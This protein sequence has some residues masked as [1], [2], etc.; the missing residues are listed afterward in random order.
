MSA[1]PFFFVKH[2][3]RAVVEYLGRFSHVAQP[4]LNFKLPF[5]S[6]VAYRHSLKEALHHVENQTA[7]TKD[8]VKIKIDGLLYYKIV[9]A[10]KAA[11]N[12]RDPVIAIASLAQT[13]MRSEIGRL[14]LDRTFQERESL[15][16]NIMRALNL[17]SEDWGIQVLRYE[18]KDIQPPAVIKR[19]MELESEAERHKRSKIL[20]SEGER[21]SKINI[22]EGY[23]TAEIMRGEGKAVQIQQEALAMAET[24]KSLGSSIT[25]GP[26]GE[27]QQDAMN[28]RLAEQYVR[29]VNEIFARAEIVILPKSMHSELGSGNPLSATSLAT[30]FTL[31]KS[32]MGNA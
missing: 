5:L 3:H 28:L 14:D 31:Y 30:A 29:V 25:M 9:D 21:Q 10:E 16:A 24:L 6:S 27:F 1:S 7:I 20:F 17:A 32:M 13:S 12:I 23:K 18:I 15:N 2:N 22:A 19:C 4:G 11:Y 8:N 26:D